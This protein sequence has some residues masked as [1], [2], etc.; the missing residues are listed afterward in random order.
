MRNKRHVHILIVSLIHLWLGSLLKL[1]GVLLIHST[2]EM[3]S[4]NGNMQTSFDSDAYNCTLHTCG[5]R[6]GPVLLPCR[7]KE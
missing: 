6:I 2:A 1:P 7:G 3:S 5:T 4:S